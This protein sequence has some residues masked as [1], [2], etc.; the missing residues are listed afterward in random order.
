MRN[1]CTVLLINV[2]LDMIA[3]HTGKILPGHVDGQTCHLGHL[4]TQV[5][6]WTWMTYPGG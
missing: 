3:S 6:A 5:Y 2:A 1:T 4:H